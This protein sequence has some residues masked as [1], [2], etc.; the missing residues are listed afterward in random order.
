MLKE[1]NAKKQDL[2][3]QSDECKNKRNDLNAQASTLASKRNDLNKQ[4]KDLI[5]EA[6]GSK[7]LRDEENVQVKENKAKRDEL[8]AKA[9]EVFAKVDALRGDNDLTGPSIKEISKDI[10]RMEYEQQTKVLTP[11]KEK[12][13]VKHI[14][15]LRKIYAEK[16]AQIEGNVELKELMTEAQKIRDEAS[17]YHN[18]LETYAQKAQEYHDKM[19][20]TF[21]EADKIRADS[22]AA[23]REFV[24]IQEKADEQHKLFIT[25][26]KEIRDIDKEIRKLKKKDTGDRRAIAMEDVRKDAEDIFAKF[27]SGEKLTT[28]NLMTLQKSGLL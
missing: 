23:H 24:G 26:Q 14:T 9:N 11:S 28:D 2:R 5:N 4:T 22:D 19:I 15:E 16:N 8:N 3:K 12:E 10:E 25:A 7:K 18:A 6:Q 20:A 27:K 21:K 17:E 13:L 1:L